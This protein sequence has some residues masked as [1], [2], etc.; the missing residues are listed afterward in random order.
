VTITLT[1]LRPRSMRMTVLTL[2]DDGIG[3]RSP[4]PLNTGTTMEIDLN[5][6]NILAI[7]SRCTPDGDSCLIGARINR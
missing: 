1:G 7:V 4:V 2:S 6:W 3:L 5:G